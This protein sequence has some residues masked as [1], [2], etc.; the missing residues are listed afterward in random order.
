V[1]EERGHRKRKVRG[2]GGEGRIGG[3]GFGVGNPITCI[4]IW[5][6]VKLCS[7]ASGAKEA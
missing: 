7:L 1:K 5:E 3:R 6:L 4:S 2:N